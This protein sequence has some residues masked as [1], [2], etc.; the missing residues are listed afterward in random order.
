MPA[1]EIELLLR[2]LDAAY[3]RQ[4]WHGPNLR[5]SVRGLEVAT[6]LFRPAPGRRNV[7]EHVVHAAYWKYIVRRRLL[8]EKR[9]SFALKGSNWFPR[10]EGLTEADWRADLDLLEKTHRSLRE[11]VAGLVPAALRH[12]PTGSKVSNLAMITGIAAHDVY[13]AGQI[14]LL[15]RLVAQS[16]ERGV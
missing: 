7:S 8:G 10:G 12:T 15:K 3:D 11:A 13:H 4:S 6:A 1:P 9:G 16:G 14:Q 5:G 2:I